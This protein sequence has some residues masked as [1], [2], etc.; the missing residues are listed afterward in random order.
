LLKLKIGCIKPEVSS[1]RAA[2]ISILR[3][4]IAKQIKLIIHINVFETQCLDDAAI[5]FGSVWVI[6]LCFLV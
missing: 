1:S 3:K 5:F 4:T 2:A 6:Y